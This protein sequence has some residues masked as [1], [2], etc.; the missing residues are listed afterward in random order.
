MTSMPRLRPWTSVPEER[1][2]A[3]H[4]GGP[5]GPPSTEPE[6]R[7]PRDPPPEEQGVPFESRPD[8]PIALAGDEGPDGESEIG[9]QRTILEQTRTGEERHEGIKAGAPRPAAQ[10]RDLERSI[11][12]E[13]PESLTFCDL[14]DRGGECETLGAALRH[15]QQAQDLDARAFACVHR[16]PRR[17]RNQGGAAQGELL[18]SRTPGCQMLQLRHDPSESYRSATQFLRVNT[19]AARRDED[20]LKITLHFHAPRHPRRPSRSPTRAR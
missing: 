16:R 11:A 4:S 9:D 12:R 1:P 18:R 14:Q 15:A 10:I 6:P 8:H 3:D 13:D 2:C 5:P 20:P 19:H 7:W 17:L